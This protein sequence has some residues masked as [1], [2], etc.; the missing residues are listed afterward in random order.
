MPNCRQTARRRSAARSIDQVEA[1]GID[2]SGRDGRRRNARPSRR[3]RPIRRTRLAPNEIEKVLH[4]LRPGAPPSSPRRRSNRPR[5]TETR[6]AGR[7]RS[8]AYRPTGAGERSALPPPPRC[9]LRRHRQSA[10]PNRRAARGGVC[11]AA[12]EQIMRR[13]QLLHTAIDRARI[14][15]IA[16]GEELLDRLRIEPT[17]ELRRRTASLSAPR[18]RSTCRREKAVIERLFAE[19]VARQEQRLDAARPR[20]QRRTSR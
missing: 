8:S 11:A 5:P 1:I 4:R 10:D 19:P 6:R 20:G 18:R 16:E 9:G 12:D 17:I 15:N 3:R 14:R 2:R 13:R 7:R